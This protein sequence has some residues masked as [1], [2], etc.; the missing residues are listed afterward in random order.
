MSLSF[1]VF[2]PQSC[3][4]G[5]QETGGPQFNLSNGDVDSLILHP[6]SQ[7]SLG[8][9]YVMLENNIGLDIESDFA[10]SFTSTVSMMKGDFL[11]GKSFLDFQEEDT[12]NIDINCVDRP[13]DLMEIPLIEEEFQ[14]DCQAEIKQTQKKLENET[15]SNDVTVGTLKTPPCI[16][17]E[18]G[19]SNLSENCTDTERNNV[20]LTPF[21]PKSTV[22]DETSVS[23]ASEESESIAKEAVEENLTLEDQSPE[24]HQME[25]NMVESILPANSETTN[26]RKKLFLEQDLSVKSNENNLKELLKVTVPCLQDTEDL[27]KLC[28][29]MG[30]HMTGIYRPK[31]RV[32]SVKPFCPDLPS[33][34]SKKTIKNIFEVEDIV[35]YVKDQGKGWYFVKWKNWHDDF[36]TWE[37]FKNLVGCQM[38]L[39]KFHSNRENMRKRKLSED[40]SSDSEKLKIKNLISTLCKSSP[41]DLATILKLRGI[42]LADFYNSNLSAKK[43]KKDLLL[44][45]SGTMKENA[46]TM[47]KHLEI[48][49]S[50]G[51]E[52]AL[53]A[54]AEK[55]KE[56]LLRLKEWERDINQL[57]DGAPIIVENH[58]DIEGPPENFTYITDYKPSEGIVIPEDPLVGCECDSCLESQK[59]CCSTQSGGLFAYNRYGY[60]KVEPGV[61]IYECNKRCKCGHTCHNRVVQHGRK[62]KLA[63]FRT[64]DGRGWGVKTLE[65][66]KKGTFVMEYVGEVITSE[67]AEKRGQIYD[68]RGRTYLFDLDYNDGDCP[69]TVDAAH[70]GNVTHFVNH[71]CDPNLVV[72]GVWINNLDPRLPRIAFFS[73][74]E[75][76][77]GEELTFDYKMT[78]ETGENH[79]SKGP[80]SPSCMNTSGEAKTPPTSPI[81][82]ESGFTPNKANTEVPQNKRIPCKCGVPNCRKY[83]F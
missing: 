4:S 27:R 65:K 21:M 43:I 20:K 54:F 78:G 46:N 42:S 34:K 26:L 49:N 7:I 53:I 25:E 58:V 32:S 38:L 15:P 9:E 13:K 70:Y 16:E 1:T 40:S 75:I 47:M 83:L 41:D 19:D 45:V 14:I 51:S 48:E 12:E 50:F 30:L 31:R 69:F 5:F 17:R 52:S 35:D 71:S 2:K 56:V 68:S 62:V 72:F 77:R 63:I 6:Q 39:K 44:T 37:P 67:E 61:P 73:R 64:D 80:M 57:S 76:K 74:R 29:K 8:D 79:L 66:I 22:N 36:N 24:P 10:E 59:N 11:D 28:L 18:T 60:L 33:E 3:V 82:D 23:L 81:K 55:R